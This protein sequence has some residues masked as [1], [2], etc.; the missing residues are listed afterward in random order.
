MRWEMEKYSGRFRE[1]RRR[2]FLRHEQFTFSS[3]LVC[4]R[5]SNYIVRKHTLGE[6]ASTNTSC[7][8]ATYLERPDPPL[9]M[10]I[11]FL[12]SFRLLSLLWLRNGFPSSSKLDLLKREEGHSSTLTITRI[13]VGKNG[14]K[15]CLCGAAFCWFL[16]PKTSRKRHIS[17]IRNRNLFNLIGSYTYSYV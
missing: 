6:V 8:E 1:N 2:V 17:G 15:C 14:R 12:L 10:D 5:N 16:F 3:R 7:E 11:V 13:L 4:L 9:R